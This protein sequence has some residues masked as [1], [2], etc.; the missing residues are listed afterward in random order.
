MSTPRHTFGLPGFSIVLHRTI[1]LSIIFFLLI[2]FTGCK[3]S[4]DANDMQSKNLR[5]FKWSID[6]LSY[7]TWGNVKDAPSVEGMWGVNDTT[8]YVYGFDSWGG[9]G[10]LWKYNGKT[11]ERAKLMASEGGPMNKGVDISCVTGFSANNIYAF[12]DAYTNITGA[13]EHEAVGLHYDGVQWTRMSLPQ[14]GS[15]SLMGSIGSVAAVSPSMIYC[16]TH[17]GLLYSYNGLSWTV[18]TLA[19]ISHAD[20]YLQINAITVNSDRSLFLQTRQYDGQKTGNLYFQLIKYANKRTTLIDSAT[21]TAPWGG[22]A[23]WQ[24]SNGNLYSSGDGGIFRRSN[25]KWVKIYSSEFVGTIFG[26]NDQHLVAVENRNVLYFDGRSWSPIY[27][28]PSNT[29]GAKIWCSD[30]DVF[31]A[32]NVGSM[33]VVAH[34]K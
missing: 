1:Q 24:S 12:G 33:L 30:T 14:A 22:S 4:V 10:T 8:V 2:N 23:F 16:G 26:A 13:F 9:A 19:Y 15:T 29:W 20:L 3:H 25:D 31:V 32:Y 34:G 28:L 7:T 27:S 6:S 11:W 17:D 21:N 5:N 18:D